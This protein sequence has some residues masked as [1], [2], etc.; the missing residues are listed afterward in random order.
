MTVLTLITMNATTGHL[1]KDIERYMGS[2]PF[3]LP[4]W[5]YPSPYCPLLLP[6]AFGPG[7]GSDFGLAGTALTSDRFGSE[8]FGGTAGVA[9]AFAL[10]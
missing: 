7:L 10:G 8:L 2:S 3:L 1:M 4:F 9:T 6:P 5:V